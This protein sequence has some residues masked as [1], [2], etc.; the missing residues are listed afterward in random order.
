[1][2]L[3]L[4]QKINDQGL[5]SIEKRNCGSNAKRLLPT[6]RSKIKAG[7]PKVNIGKSEIPLFV[8]DAAPEM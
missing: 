5:P 4:N 6:D 7:F 1:M 8:A 3:Y 2:A